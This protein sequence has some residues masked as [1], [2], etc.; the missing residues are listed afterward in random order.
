MARAG[1]EGAEEQTQHSLFGILYSTITSASC[2]R[3]TITELIT[4][5]SKRPQAA[6]P[7]DGGILVYGNCGRRDWSVFR[8]RNNI[9]PGHW[10]RFPAVTATQNMTRSTMFWFLMTGGLN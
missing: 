3:A 5:V 7:A 9:F 8:P 10:H 4:I 2:Q 1:G 6:G